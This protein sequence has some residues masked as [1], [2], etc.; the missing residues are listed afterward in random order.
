M[1]TTLTNSVLFVW[2]LSVGLLFS[3]AKAIEV[4]D[5]HFTELNKRQG[6]SDTTVLDVVED[7]AGYIWLATS[8]GLN[9]Y[10]GYEM[11]QYHPSDVDTSS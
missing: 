11:K 2:L 3:T 6:L 1:R 5:L 4:S 10:S 9:R 7:G 8:N